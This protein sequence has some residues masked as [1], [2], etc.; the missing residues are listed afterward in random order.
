MKKLCPIILFLVAVILLMIMGCTTFC[1][2][3]D[4]SKRY[5]GKL[6]ECA[7][8]KFMCN[9][10]E[11]YFSNNCGC[12]C[13]F[14]NQN[15]SEKENLSDNPIHGVMHPDEA[16]L[17]KW[18][19][20]LE[21]EPTIRA[22]EA[23]GKVIS[24]INKEN[25]RYEVIFSINATNKNLG[26]YTKEYDTNSFSLILNNGLYPDSKFLKKYHIILGKEF[27]CYINV[28]NKNIKS[29]EVIKL[30]YN[31]PDINIYDINSDFTY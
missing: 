18:H 4:P 9:P 6:G 10:G 31:C 12:G 27:V 23:V 17:K 25:N 14:L 2:Y 11:K 21:R 20:D 13:I 16:M 22:I 5:E 8:I 26:S 24:I 15:Q 7:S 1:N 19:E 29:D 30:E 3:N 28:I